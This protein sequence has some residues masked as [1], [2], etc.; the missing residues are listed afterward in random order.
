M[1]EVLI[2]VFESA[3]NGFQKVCVLPFGFF[4]LVYTMCL[5]NLLSGFCVVCMRY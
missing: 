1:T 4:V 2:C 3:R 5:V